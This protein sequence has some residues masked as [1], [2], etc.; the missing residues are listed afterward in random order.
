M[1]KHNIVTKQF[2]EKKSIVCDLCGMEYSY[3]LSLGQTEFL[4]AKEF[5]HIHHVGGYGSIL[6][7]GV[8]IN[9]DICQHC[10]Q[11]YIVNKMK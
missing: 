1:I 7:D 10:F 9:V 3:D 2:A 5:L 11:Q 4:E 8:S 6:G